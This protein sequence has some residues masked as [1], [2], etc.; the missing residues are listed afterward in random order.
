MVLASDNIFSEGCG[1]FIPLQSSVL[2]AIAIPPEIEPLGTPC[3]LLR[4][5]RLF[6]TL[7]VDYPFTLGIFYIV[8]TPRHDSLGR[9]A[10]AIGALAR[11]WTPVP[12]HN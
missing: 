1:H 5:L 4:I 12:P 8:A 7:S 3:R 11:D 10:R 2:V 6:V 9:V